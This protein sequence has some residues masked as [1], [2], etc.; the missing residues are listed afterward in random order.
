MVVSGRAQNCSCM[1]I[2]SLTYLGRHVSALEQGSER[3]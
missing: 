2:E 1:P 3:H